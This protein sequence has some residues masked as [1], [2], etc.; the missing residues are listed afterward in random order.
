MTTIAITERITTV[1]NIELQQNCTSTYTQCNTDK[2]ISAAT[3]SNINT[4]TT[5]LYVNTFTNEPSIKGGL[6]EKIKDTIFISITSA[7]VVIITVVILIMIFGKVHMSNRNMND[8]KEGD[9]L[10][11]YNSSSLSNTSFPYYYSSNGKRYPLLNTTSFQ[12]HNYKHDWN[13][14]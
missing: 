8:H 7:T 12:M 9:T 4:E 6:N 13:D 11:L 5:T 14:I 10:S 2:T 1:N 3:I